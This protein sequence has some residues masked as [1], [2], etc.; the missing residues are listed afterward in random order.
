MSRIVVFGAGGRGGR[1]AVDEAR[2]RG[3][4]VTAVVRDPDRHPDL[5]SDGVR[6]VAGDVTEA[7]DV[8]RIAAGH[9]AAISSVYD[10][11]T[12]PDVFFTAAARALL[13]GLPRAGVPR[14]VVVGL[15][16]VLETADG[17][18]LMDTAGYP[19]EYRSFS[20]GHAAG[21]A[22]LRAESGLDWV[23]LSPAG[24]F[25]HGGARTGRY[26]TA[27]AEAGSRISYADFAI[28]L[29]DEIDRPTAY[30]IQLGVERG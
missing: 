14:L 4:Q 24:D 12:A 27:S 5:G 15:A 10:P 13:A 19:Q 28:A 25:D 18:P 29:L 11:G 21:M 3:H 1:A 2:R 16:S 30:R 23:V 9:Q 6:L 8:A 20:L 22:V 7:A 26:R 17:T